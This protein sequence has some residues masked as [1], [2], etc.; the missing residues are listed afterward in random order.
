MGS[1]FLLSGVALN[2]LVAWVADQN[3]DLDL[4]SLHGEHAPIPGWVIERMRGFSIEGS[5]RYKVG[6]VLADCWIGR[7]A[8]AGGTRLIATAGVGWPCIA[9]ESVFI[10]DYDTS[11]FPI[12]PPEVTELR[13]GGI[14]VEWPD[15]VPEWVPRRFKWR[16]VLPGYALNSVFFGASAYLAAAAVSMEYRTVRRWRRLARGRCDTCGYDRSGIDP[17]AK[18]PECGT[19]IANG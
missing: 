8:P 6:S 4:E 14:R 7:D 10:H 15:W 2:L 1:A 9:V 17:A 19:R 18:C 3:H 16:P 13:S 11:W 5:E 12:H